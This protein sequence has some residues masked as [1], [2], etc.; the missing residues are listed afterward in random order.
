MRSPC[1]VEVG[2]VAWRD[3]GAWGRAAGGGGGVHGAAEP[4]AR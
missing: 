1:G 3:V 4:E 2:G